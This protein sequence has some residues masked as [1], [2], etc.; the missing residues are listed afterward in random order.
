MKLREIKDK[1]DLLYRK[2]GD[3]DVFIRDL[4]SGE[5]LDPEDMWAV[6]VGPVFHSVYIGTE[7]KEGGR[8]MTL[9]DMKD[10]LDRLYTRYGD[11]EVEVFI[12]DPDG[13]EPLVA[14]DMWAIVDGP[15]LHA[16]YI[17]TERRKKMSPPQ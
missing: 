11:G 7:K 6:L 8:L 16:V 4:D 10:Y 3:A 1:L 15:V 14:E 9:K 12:T 2:Y 5:R 17:G 13:G